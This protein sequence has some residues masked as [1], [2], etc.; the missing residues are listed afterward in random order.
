MYEDSSKIHKE[1]LMFVVSLHVCVI[2]IGV[3]CY[4]SCRIIVQTLTNKPM[5]RLFSDLV[6]NS[7]SIQSKTSVI[8]TNI[9][10]IA[11]TQIMLWILVM[12]LELTENTIFCVAL[13]MSLGNLRV[14]PKTQSLVSVFELTV[15]FLAMF[16]C[17]LHLFT[18]YNQFPYQRHFFDITTL[19]IN[20]LC[21]ATGIFWMEC[22][23]IK[24]IIHFSTNAFCVCFMQSLLHVSLTYVHMQPKLAQLQTVP[25]F[26]ALT[27]QPFFIFM[28]LMIIVLSIANHQNIQI[29]TCFSVAGMTVHSLQNAKDFDLVYFLWGL[30]MVLSQ[31]ISLYFK[32]N[33]DVGS[34]DSNFVVEDCAES[35]E[36]EEQSIEELSVSVSETKD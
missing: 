9:I 27:I 33:H 21:I 25:F 36:E 6:T 2:G 15:C 20:L 10:M 17:V 1:I 23:A 28:C 24:N 34:S 13:G 8:N 35:L 22:K 14:T 5:Y 30:A 31:T 3:F 19:S 29:M 11:L 4:W 16:V 26:Y 32:Q 7:V 12:G 18:P